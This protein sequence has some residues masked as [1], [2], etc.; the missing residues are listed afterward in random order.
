MFAFGAMLP[1]A[2]GLPSMTGPAAP[3]ADAIWLTGVLAG[4]ALWLAAGPR[5]LLRIS[6]RAYVLGY[7][8]LLL[9]A[10]LLGFGLTISRRLS[11]GWLVMTLCIALMLM[12]LSLQWRWAV[13]GALWSSLSLVWAAYGLAWAFLSAPT[14]VFP[15]P[16]VAYAAGAVTAFAM[17]VAHLRLRADER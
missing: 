11:L 1:I 2:F 9:A 3:F 7:T 16:I 12:L 6:L 4:P 8:V 10:G 13:V 14:A 5:R 15:T 17:S